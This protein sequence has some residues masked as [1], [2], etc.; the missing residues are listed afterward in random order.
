V[1]PDLVR[2]MEKSITNSPHDFSITEG[3]RTPERQRELVAQGAS[4]TLM[5]RHL[6]G[7]AVDIAIIKDGKAVWDFP[8]YEEVANHI[9]KVAASEGVA[10]VWGGRWRGLRDGPHY[11][12]DRKVY[13]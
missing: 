6:T 5:S 8:L 1:H 3:L 2:V 7:H 11:E 4:R 12:L 13:K 9:E 10:I